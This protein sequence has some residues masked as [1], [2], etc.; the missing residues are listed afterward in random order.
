MRNDRDRFINLE[1]KTG[2]RLLSSTS[3][4]LFFAE[5]SGL[6]LAAGQLGRGLY[7]EEKAECCFL[8]CHTF[9][10]ILVQQS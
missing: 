6:W 1:L 3:S 9:P 10:V 7:C 8:M 5:K 2:W 4:F